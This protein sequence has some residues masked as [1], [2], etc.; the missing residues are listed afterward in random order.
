MQATPGSVVTRGVGVVHRRAGA[1]ASA[2][3]SRTTRAPCTWRR[4][5]GAAPHRF[6]E[7]ARFARDRVAASSPT[8]MPTFIDAYGPALT[9]PARVVISAPTPAMRQSGAS[10]SAGTAHVASGQAEGCVDANAGSAM[11]ASKT[12]ITVGTWS[13]R[14]SIRL[15]LKICGTSTQSAR[16][17]VS[18]W[19]KR[20]V[21]AMPGELPL[22][23]LEPGLD[24][25]PVPA[26]LVVVGDLQLV[27]CR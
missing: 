5:T 3:P 20:P 25:V 27:D 1:A 14:Q 22:D 13:S 6:G 8:A 24:P 15:A 2:T 7:R 11:H 17:G 16:P 9:P 23:D 21:A 4:K 26:V 12:R 18:P 19:Q 10:Q